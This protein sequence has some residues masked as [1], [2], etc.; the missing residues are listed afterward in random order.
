MINMQGAELKQFLV[1]VTDNHQLDRL[2]TGKHL[3]AYARFEC[4][5]K[6]QSLESDQPRTVQEAVLLLDNIG[7][8]VTDL[9]ETETPAEELV[10]ALK[11]DRLPYVDAE[12][13]LISWGDLVP[14]IE[15]DWL[16][17]MLVTEKEGKEAGFSMINVNKG[18]V[19]PEPVALPDA[20]LAF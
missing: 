8:T 11:N 19:S 4:F 5:T 15:T 16:I 3:L 17:T 12:K 1:R 2:L 7:Q 13:F 10:D 14:V 9:A 6:G 20:F 18:K